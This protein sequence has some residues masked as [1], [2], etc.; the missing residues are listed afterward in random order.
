LN[1]EINL[2]V[3]DRA[4]VRELRLLQERYF[5]NSERLRGA[6]WRKR[7]LRDKVFQNTARLMDS[8]L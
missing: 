5:A 4:V 1:A 6:A 3:Y 7:S 8:F 2:V